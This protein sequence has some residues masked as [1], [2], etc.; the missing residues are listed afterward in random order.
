MNFSHNN[1]TSLC[2]RIRAY[3]AQTSDA[4]HRAAPSGTGSRSQRSEIITALLWNS[5]R[6]NG[7]ANQACSIFLIYSKSSIK[8]FP[9]LFRRGVV[10]AHC[11]DYVGLGR[12]QIKTN[13][14]VHNQTSKPMNIRL[15]IR[16]VDVDRIAVLFY[17]R[18]IN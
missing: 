9:L 17:R 11:D 5:Y 18:E 13:P 12:K 16:N 14:L 15:F 7:I 2:A 1:A 8:F 10:V 6:L 3:V 4:D